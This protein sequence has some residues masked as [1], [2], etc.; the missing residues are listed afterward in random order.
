MDRE[1]DEGVDQEECNRWVDRCLRTQRFAQCWQRV[2]AVI[3]QRRGETFGASVG[4][5]GLERG[6]E[7]G[8][9]GGV[10]TLSVVQTPARLT[11]NLAPEGGQ[12]QHLAGVGACR[13]GHLSAAESK[14]LLI[15]I[16]SST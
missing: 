10:I 14:R 4:V 16:Y 11:H 3:E 6:V 1:S 15:L 12:R 7:S 13:G 2:G 9:L 5:A 8:A